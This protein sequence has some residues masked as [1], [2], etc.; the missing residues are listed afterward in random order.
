MSNYRE[1]KENLDKIRAE[2]SCK[3]DII[4]TIWN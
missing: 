1:S 3:G 2:Y 4:F